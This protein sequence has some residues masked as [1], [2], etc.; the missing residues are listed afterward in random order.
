MAKAKTKKKIG[1][2]VRRGRVENSRMG[3]M[4]RA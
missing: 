3:E 1:N 4:E 2:K